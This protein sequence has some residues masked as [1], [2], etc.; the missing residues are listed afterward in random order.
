MGTCIGLERSVC[1]S[2]QGALPMRPQ[3]RSALIKPAI[4]LEM[5]CH[6]AMGVALGLGFALALTLTNAFGVS[7][8]IAHSHE[9]RMTLML[10]VATFTLAFAVGATLTGFVF[11][12]MQER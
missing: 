4:V 11:T 1:A 8:L 5:A 6:T 7:T 10:F 3:K 9:P 12:M 2:E